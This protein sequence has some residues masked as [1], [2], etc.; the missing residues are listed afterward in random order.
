MAKYYV[1]QVNNNGKVLFRL[2]QKSGTHKLLQ[3][4]NIECIYHYFDNYTDALDFYTDMNIL[5]CKEDNKCKH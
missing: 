5:I 2:P 4:N 3:G 1:A